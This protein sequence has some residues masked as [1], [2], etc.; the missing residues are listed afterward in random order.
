MKIGSL[1][2][3]IG[4]L[5]LGLERAGLGEVVWQ[6]EKDAFCREVL[7]RHWPGVTRYDDVKTLRGCDVE[8]VDILCGGFPCQDVSSAGKGAGL[9]GAR[10]GLWYEYLRIVS[11]LRPRIVVVE[12]VASGK[13]RWLP[14]IRRGLEALGYETMALEIGAVDV[15]AP[16]RRLRVFVVAYAHGQGQGQPALSEHGEVGRACEAAVVAPDS[17]RDELRVEQGGRSG[18]DGHGTRIARDARKTWLAPDASGPGLPR[19]ESAP[20]PGARRLAAEGAWS[21]D[22]MPEPAIRRVDD[23]LPAR[24]DRPRQRRRNQRLKALGNAVVPQCAE[25]VGR[26]ILERAPKGAA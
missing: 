13:R 15:G 26:W 22:A 16:H 9:A 24:V 7:A 14:E 21:D 11:E 8:P 4:G 10:S 18:S 17:Y 12:N 19:A 2:S 25:E 23:G 6:C 3:G 20:G 1:F 5:E